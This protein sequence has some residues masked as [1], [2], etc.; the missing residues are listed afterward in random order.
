MTDTNLNREELERFQKYLG[1]LR[2]TGRKDATLQA[3]ASSHREF[4]RFLGGRTLKDVTGLD[5]R[6]WKTS[7]L[8]LSRAP[9]TINSRLIA[10]KAYADWVHRQDRLTDQQLQ[11]IRAVPEIQ[12]PPLGAKTL[13]PEEFQRFLRTIELQASVRDRAII[14]LLLSGLRVSEVAGLKADDIEMNAHRGSIQIRG[15]HVKRSAYRQVPLSKQ[16]R[17]YL[18]EHLNAKP[19]G[20]VFHGERGALTTDGIYKIVVKY[21]C[22][23]GIDIHPHQLRHEFSRLYLAA[24]QNDLVALQNLLGHAQLETTARFY[25]RKTMENLREGVDRISL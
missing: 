13:P 8:S 18:T 19:C 6:N 1:W 3:Y 5:L 23:A 9:A 17:V 14:Y 24:N 4:F 25:A 21:G 10:I 20:L 12:S 2:S 15:E 22:L 7:M 11:T 16:S